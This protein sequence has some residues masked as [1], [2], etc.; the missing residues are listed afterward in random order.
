MQLSIT[1]RGSFARQVENFFAHRGRHLFDRD[2]RRAEFG[3]QRNL[4]TLNQR[5][6]VKEYF[7]GGQLHSSARGADAKPPGH[8]QFQRIVKFSLPLLSVNKL[9][10]RLSNHISYVHAARR[11]ILDGPF[12][13]H[14]SPLLLTATQLR[15]N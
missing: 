14:S 11:S 10:N 8:V 7:A 12:V 3:R 13:R 2:W 6:I 15:L 9:F 1:Y 5:L 4:A